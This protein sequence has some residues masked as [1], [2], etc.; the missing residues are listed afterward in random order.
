MYV[1]PQSPG[2][3]YTGNLHSS[4]NTLSQKQILSLFNYISHNNNNN[5]ITLR[6]SDSTRIDGIFTIL[7][8]SMRGMYVPIR[9]SALHS[10]P[11]P[12]S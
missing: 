1:V 10:L 4:Y 6:T 11:Q 8:H 3:D 7:G 2:P 12:H 5:S 9:P